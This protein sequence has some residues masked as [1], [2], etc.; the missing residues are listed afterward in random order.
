MR[1][2]KQSRAWKEAE[3]LTARLLGGRRVLR[4][5]DF[6]K[7]DVDVIVDDFPMLRVDSKYRTRWSHHRFLEEVQ[8]KY[9]SEPEHVPVLVTKT[10]HQQGAFVTMKLE[11][12]GVLLDAVRELRVERDQRPKGPQL[13]RR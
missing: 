7:S 2:A 5:A 11:H 1:V 10:H 8:K 13:K 9:C 4:G 12:L 6:S 3:K